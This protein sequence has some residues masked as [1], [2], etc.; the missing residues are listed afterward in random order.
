MSSYM[1]RMLD[2]Q[3]KETFYSRDTNQCF[4]KWECVYECFDLFEQIGNSDNWN[5]NKKSQ[6]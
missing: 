6:E 1:A 4:L 2:S 5:N 3:I